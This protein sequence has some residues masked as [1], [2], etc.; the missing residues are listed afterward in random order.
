MHIGKIK[1]SF[2][3]TPGTTF[4]HESRDLFVENKIISA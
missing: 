3:N 1:G 2:E 4:K